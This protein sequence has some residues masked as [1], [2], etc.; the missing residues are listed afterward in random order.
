M[1]EPR[2]LKGF[3]DFLPETM[4][5][6]KDLIEKL[7]LLFKRFGFLP[8]D[9]PCLEYTEILLGKG[10]G[11]TD[12]QIY[13]F[14]D[15]G[16]RDVALR[17]DLTVPLARFVSEHMNELNFPF[18]RYHIAPVWRGENTQRGR[19]REF[20]QCDFDILGSDSIASDLEILLVIQNGFKILNAG[21]FVINVNSRKILNKILEKYSEKDKY[22]DILREVDKTYKIGIENVIKNLVEN[23][24]LDSKIAEEI[25]S[26]LGLNEENIDNGITGSNIFTYLENLQNKLGASEDIERVLSLFSLIEKLNLLD[27]YALNPAITRGL[28]YYTGIVFETF[29]KDRKN[30]GSVCSGG[31]YDNLTSLYS[32][33]PV[34]GI[35]GSFGLD[36]LLSLMEDKG[37]LD[38]NRSYV[39]LII[40]NM[41]E[42][43]LADYQT[44]ATYFRESGLNVEI[45]LDNQ[46]IANQFKFAEKNSIKYCLIAGETE[47]EKG[48]YNLKE[49]ET[50]K[51]IKMLSKEDILRNIK[52]TNS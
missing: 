6:K 45:F 50:G 44:L 14:T 4:I 41:G 46:K 22:G 9:T 43:H 7:E 17:F 47:I 3:R 40:F 39:N 13:R 29:I 16:G 10:S 42:K 26:L 19:Y 27:Y 1:I 20:F 38:K 2:I 36:R 49:L 32:K 37:V 34:T 25:I 11:E 15:H 23:I 51:E 31:R 24:K 28:D 48:L 8:I 33:R 18:K 21:D 35:G 12:K 30:F 5:G 52:E